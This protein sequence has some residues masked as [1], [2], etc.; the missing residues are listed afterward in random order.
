VLPDGDALG[1]MLALHLLC[2]AHGCRSVAAWP[3]SDPVAPHYL[4]LPGLDTITPASEF[5]SSPEV[6]VTFDCGSIERLGE[7]AAP[8]RAAGELVVLDHHATNALF[9]TINLVDPQAAATAVVVR[10]LA[11]RLGWSLDRDSAECI[12][13]GLVTDT[14]RFQY[15]NTTPEV[16]ALAEELAGFDLPIAYIT[17]ELFE[18]SR[19]AYLQLVADVL[20]R[21][22]LDES[23]GL[24]VACVTGEDLSRHGVTLEET[25]GLIDLVRRTA[26]AQVAVVA[27]EAPEGTRV[28]LRS[29]DGPDVGA[30]AQ[31]LGG[32][33]HRYASGFTSP[34][35]IGEVVASV[36]QALAALDPGSSPVR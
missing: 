34:R 23:L 29:I 7:L 4:F 22:E 16:F 8:A 5:P 2:R 30:L 1:S 35:P 25:E 13:T 31:S 27:K 21:T 26:E 33:G 3:G 20:G 15:S 24:V 9:G 10:R 14:G 12:Y 32:G 18:K 17:R 11:D 28:S 6:M 36:R 19:F